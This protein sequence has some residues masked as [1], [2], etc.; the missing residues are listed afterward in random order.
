MLL[1]HIFTYGEWVRVVTRQQCAL[2]ARK[3]NGSVVC[4]A[5]QGREVPREAQLEHCARL[6]ALQSEAELLERAQR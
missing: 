2:V 6:W 3:A 1:P 5:G 4:I